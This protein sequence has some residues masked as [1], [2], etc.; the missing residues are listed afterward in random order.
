M[1]PV[2]DVRPDDRLLTDAKLPAWGEW[3]LATGSVFLLLTFCAFLLAGCGMGTVGDAGPVSSTPTHLGLTGSVYGGQQPISGATIQLWQVG[4]TGYGSGAQALGTSVQTSATG[5]F[6]ITGDYSC[7]NAANGG[8][9]EVYITAS[10]GNPGLQGQVNNTAIL[11]MATLGTCGSLSGSTFIAIN[12]LSTVAAAYSL[13][14][15]MSPSG[16]IGAYSGSSQGLTNAFA[17][18]GNLV[19]L[20]TGQALSTTPNGNGLVPQSKLNTIADILATCVNTAGPGSPACTALFS[21]ATPSGGT[22]PTT[23]LAAALSMALN[24]ANNVTALLNMPD[25]TAPFQPIVA[26]ANDWT[27]A[28]DYASGGSAPNSLALDSAGNV[29]VGNYGTGG[30]NSTVSMMTPTGVTATN[31]PFAS[32]SSINGISGLAIDSSNT[33]WVANHDNNSVAQLTASPSGATYTVATGLGPFTSGGLSSPSAIAVDGSANVWLVNNG[34]NSLTEL[35]HSNY[36]AAATNFTGIGLTTPQSIAFDSVGNAWV[37]SPSVGAVTEFNPSVTP[38]LNATYTVG[39]LTN[40]TSLAIDGF[41]NVWVTDSGLGKVAELSST[42]ITISPN[43][44]ITGGGITGSTAQAIDGSGNIWIADKT[45]GRV[46]V[47]STFGVPV[48]PSTGYQDSS[49]SSPAALAIDASG[50]VWVA[51]SNPVTKNSKVLTVS[52]IIGA[53]SPAVM[54]LSSAVRQAQLALKPGTPQP[55]AAAAGP[56]SGAVNVP[57]TFNG[58]ASTDPKSQT[59]SYSW[60]FGD[61]S[62]ASGAKP[63]HT[64]LTAATYP[65]T[66]TVTDT[67]G[68]NGLTSTAAVVAVATVQPPTL[69]TGGPYAGTAYLPVNFSAAGSV[70]PLNPTAGTYGLSFSWNFGDGLSGGGPSPVHTYQA[71]GNYTV[72]VTAT[73]PTGGTATATTTAVIVPGTAPV[74]APSAV[75]GGPYTGTVGTAVNF[76]GSASSDPN[77]LAL[78]YLWSFGDGGSALVASPSYTYQQAGNYS[79]QLT[80]S[81]GKTSVTSGTVAT[82][83]AAPTQ[84]NIVVNTG[85]PYT[86]AVQQP[87]TFNGTATTNPTGRQLIYTWDFGDGTTAAGGTP[88]HIYT[89]KGAYTVHLNV[90]DGQNLTANGATLATVT[91][92]PA[93][94]I[95]ANAGGP[96]QNVTSQTISFDGSRTSDNLGNTVTYSWAFGDGS[97]GTGVQPQ[98][99]YTT[100]GNYTATLTAT[101]GA[102]TATATAGVTITTAIGV[103]LTS[104]APNALFATP[105]VT[106]TGTTSLPNLTVNVNGVN[107]TVSGSSF[108]ATGVSLREGVNLISATATDGH[109]GIGTGVVSVQL[110]VTPPTASI[111]SP[112]AG[113][114][115]TNSQIA[116]AGLV[117]D[118]VTGSVGSSNV[119]L[120]VNGLSAQVANGSFLLPSLQLV[121]GQ[122][123]ITVVVSDTVGNHSQISE[124]VTVLPPNNQ[125]SLTKISGDSQTGQVQAVATQPLVVQ[126][127]SASG[128]PVAGRPITFTVTRSD[129]VVE[130]VP[131]AGQ[132]LTVTTDSTG[133]ASVL[134]KLGSRTGLGINQVSATTAGAAGPALFTASTTPGP[135]AQID[136]VNGDNQRGLL[137]Q[138]LAQSFQAI[139]LDATGN[140]VSGVS[141]NFT[142]VGAS[143]GV[144]A[145]ATVVSDANGKVFNGF[146]LGQQEG[147]NNYSVNADFTGDTGNPVSFGASAYAPGPI[148]NTSLSGVVMDNSNSPV[149]NAT[150]TITGSGLS[151]VT[152]TSGNFTINNAP[153][154]TVTFTVDGSTATSTQTFPFLSFVIQDLPGQ[155]NSL[156]K[157]IYLP[158]IDVN[159]AQTVGGNQAVTLTMAG[160]P[161]V[162]FT[163]A[164]NSVTFPDGSTVGK[165]SLS[166]V[167]AD[168]VPMEP[169]N[170]TAPNLIWTLQPAG[171]I[172][173]VPVQVTLPNTQ[174]L[175]P[176][177]V[178]EIF[179]YDHNLE[180]FVSSGTGHVSADGSVIVSD[181]GFGITKAGWGHGGGTNSP[182]G[183]VQ[184]CTS[185]DPCITATLS[186]SR[187]LCRTTPNPGT[188]CGASYT[189]SDGTTGH[190]CQLPGFCDQFGICRGAYLKAGTPCDAAKPKFCDQGGECSGG[191]A[192]LSTGT[193]PDTTDHQQNGITSADN[194]AVNGTLDLSSITPIQKF[195]AK[196]GGGA[197]FTVTINPLNA[198]NTY[199]CCEAKKQLNM[200]I[201]E[202]AAGG[203]VALSSPMFPVVIAGLPLSFTVGNFDIGITAQLSGSVGGS[204]THRKNTCTDKDCHV[205]K[206]SSQASLTFEAK[207]PAG[208]VDISLKLTGGFQLDVSTG[209]SSVGFVISTIPVTVTGD[210]AIFTGAHFVASTTLIPSETLFGGTYTFP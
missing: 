50:N 68:V 134:F 124:V 51:N 27:V 168:E 191:K 176:G 23:T 15:F 77:S 129:G 197:S 166:Q 33:V 79:V 161:G 205:F 136:A 157:P 69:Q 189:A 126:L 49:I 64:Y 19:P 135:P 74:G 83:T 209:C 20:A 39:G 151:T 183:C 163:V 67:D 73:T 99:A 121:P 80:V 208:V 91:A 103:T 54:P 21:A 90:T 204:L 185:T 9:T 85:G 119:T 184:S 16:S 30:T 199:T 192:C 143:D 110:D 29:W 167:K 40:P 206:L 84:S 201:T 122:N 188:A 128:T 116:V 4:S 138:Q 70:D 196:I 7:S 86:T 193:I 107:A 113:A 109:G 133:K 130:V 115:L 158:S 81:N 92:P 13:A 76:N 59:L 5:F 41:A 105:T 137:G 117:N 200:L 61:G 32:G 114:T 180:Q 14:Q 174:G 56:V 66:L 156:S 26:S 2:A 46:S 75:P 100:A 48:S 96:Y 131:N 140:P 150:V 37:S 87:V 149:A 144:L 148:A 38:A 57:I 165:L 95:S 58:S 179:Q 181:P 112:Q 60:T 195:L 52:E 108:T 203:S 142:S 104:P 169:S 111:T 28:I 71:A 45:G 102:V 175:P 17:T 53:A 11:Q 160:V 164:P 42:G 36:S 186:P 78:T 118:T 65:V 141:V 202:D 12:E 139:V 178:A 198:T 194:L 207:L 44:G 120:T 171:T 3:T 18:V 6:D 210:V 22:A 170:G 25:A 88:S 35:S 62:G 173:S 177:Y 34:N 72:S 190:S 187:C 93:E 97:T 10:G 43:A 63:T 94:A 98:H 123:T 152:N 146:T 155:N 125:L 145:H 106:V 1:L 172:F 82:I 132:A 162:A 159:N 24:P 182:F 101:S 89:Q 153:V 8:N 47:L 127:T 154:G 147:I 55:V 31:S